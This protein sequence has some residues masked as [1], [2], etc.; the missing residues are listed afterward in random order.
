VLAGYVVE[1]GTIRAEALAAAVYATLL[2]AAQRV[3]STPV[4]DTRRRV[5]R[6]SGTIELL[7]GTSADVTRETLMGSQ[8]TALRLLAAAAVA[9]GAALLL[10]HL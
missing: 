10:L 3:L 2:S 9:L 8:E 7:D 4:R 1:A 6:V 5:A